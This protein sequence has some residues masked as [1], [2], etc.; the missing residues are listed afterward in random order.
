MTFDSL[1]QAGSATLPDQRP[2]RLAPAVTVIAVCYNHERFVV[3]CLDS[4]RRQTF[5]DFELIVI[6][7]KSSDASVELI[8]SWIEKNFPQANFI[9]HHTNIGLCKTLNEALA[10]AAGEFIGL[11]ATDDTWLEHKLERQVAKLRELPADVA[12]VFSDAEQMDE[13][14]TTLPESFIQAHRPAGAGDDLHCFEQL[15]EGNF[16]PAMATLI[17]RSALKEIGGYDERLSY[18]DYDMWLRLADRYTLAF[19]PDIVARYRIVTTSMVRTLFV[20]PN[21]RHSYSIFLIH[22]KWIDSGR[23][24]PAQRAQ[25]AHKIFTTAYSLYLADDPRAAYC[26]R[27]AARLQPRARTLLLALTASLGLSRSRAK[28]IAAIVGVGERAVEGQK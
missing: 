6:D 10:L 16:I 25:W 9:A 13:Q 20:R 24:T 15:A 23:L 22:E 3:E 11:I 2:V 1:V 28:R 5:T 26:L 27:R 19:L 21:P 7:D 17:R 18:E 14:G 8:S 4:I 12:L